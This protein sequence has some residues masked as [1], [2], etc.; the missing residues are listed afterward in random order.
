M[1]L[2]LIFV[3]AFA[4]AL[5]IYA[6][7]EGTLLE[8][9]NLAMKAGLNV[10]PI[11]ICAFVIIGMFNTLETSELI[12][13]NFGSEAGFRGI[14]NGTLA[15]MLTPGSPFIALPIASTLLKSGAGIGP[16][17]AY[18][19]AW[20]TWELLRTPIEIGFLG[21]RF[22]LV[23]WCSIIVLPL[24]GGLIAKACFSWVKF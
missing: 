10:L 6:S 22:V 21:W 5:T 1:N 3:S 18:F 13:R 11:L 9:L 7:I 12:K 15:G 24:I 2:T 4:L 20:T 14:F 8:G 16:T 23:K 19:I 17:I